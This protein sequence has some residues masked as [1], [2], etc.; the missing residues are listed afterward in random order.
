[1]EYSLTKDNKDKYIDITA[2]IKNGMVHWPGDPD[3]EIKKI[4]DMSKG[5]KANVTSISMSAHTATH[6]DAPKHFINSGI[7][8]SKVDLNAFIGKAKVIHIKDAHIINAQELKSYSIDEGD[9]LL[10]RT[11]NSDKNWSE[12]NFNDD[13]VYVSVD[14]ANYLVEKKVLTVGV[15][16]LSVA[17]KGNGEEVHQILL[18]NNITVIEGLY[19]PDV[20]PGEYELISLPLKIDG[21]D[22]A[23]VRAILKK[24]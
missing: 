15:D 20:N 21:S 13:Y 6:A 22:G 16:Y 1:M 18:K 5:D 3:V 23:P 24:L 7:D 2:P 8:I 17:E 14:A 11:N 4:Q 19:M 12:E 10:F 9:R